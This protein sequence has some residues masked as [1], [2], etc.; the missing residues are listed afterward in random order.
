MSDCFNFNDS[1]LTEEQIKSL[2]KAQEEFTLGI[3]REDQLRASIHRDINDRNM[4]D[5]DSEIGM[6]KCEICGKSFNV[7]ENISKRDI[8][9]A[10]QK[11]IGVLLTTKILYLDMP[12]N[13]AKY[14]LKLVRTLEKVPLLHKII[15]NILCKLY[16]HNN[17]PCEWRK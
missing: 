16:N 5:L 8:K 11:L 17:K 1:L 10:T 3:S 9:K 14:S 2:E 13:I 4:L 15:I 7:V 12:E 6:A